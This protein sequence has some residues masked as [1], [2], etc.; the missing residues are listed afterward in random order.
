MSLRH[1]VIDFTTDGAGAA[2]AYSAPLDG[3]VLFVRLV[4]GTLDATA[5]ITITDNASGAAI[6]TATNLAADTDYPVRAQAKD[7]TGAAITGSFVPT[8]VSGLAKVVV[9]QGGAT[10]AGTAHLWVEE[11]R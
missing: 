9:A 4:K 11:C 8:I 1:A 2:T 7:T 3:Q 6:L 5:D 10:K